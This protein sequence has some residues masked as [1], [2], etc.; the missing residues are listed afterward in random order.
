MF[1]LLRDLN[2]LQ[3][4][5]LNIMKMHLDIFNIKSDAGIDRLKAHVL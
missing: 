1:Q 5:I 4:D 3:S 2:E